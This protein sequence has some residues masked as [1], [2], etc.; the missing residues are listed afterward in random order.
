MRDPLSK[1]RTQRG[2]GGIM[3]ST[4]DV[5]QHKANIKTSHHKGHHKAHQKAHLTAHLTA[6]R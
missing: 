4:T 6:H 1:M 2:L 5:I 3:K